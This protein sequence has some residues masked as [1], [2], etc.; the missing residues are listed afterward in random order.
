MTGPRYWH[1]GPEG[2]GVGEFLLPPAE[3]GARYTTGALACDAGAVYRRDRVYVTTDRNAARI[4]AASWPRGVVYEVE[5]VGDLEP[6]PDCSEPGLSFACARA[7]VLRVYFL[8]R[9]ERERVVAAFFG[10][11]GAG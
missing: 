4:F 7:R 1:G 6:D 8:S 2:R 11:R 3:T 10:L 5:P 9:K